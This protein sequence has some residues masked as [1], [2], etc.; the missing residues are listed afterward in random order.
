MGNN[1]KV[2]LAQIALLIEDGVLIGA[3]PEAL[4]YQ[5]MLFELSSTNEKVAHIIFSR[6]R[7]IMRDEVSPVVMET[8]EKMKQV[9][10]GLARKNT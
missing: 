6:V 3:V 10:T 2:K 5:P 4:R 8:Y 1:E 7:K 9:A